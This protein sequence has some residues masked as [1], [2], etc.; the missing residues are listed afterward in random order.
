MKPIGPYHISECEVLV[1]S[2]PFKSPIQIFQK[3]GRAVL[4]ERTGLMVALTVQNKNETLVLQTEYSPLPGIDPRSEDDINKQLPLIKQAI[5]QGVNKLK[6]NGLE[7]YFPRGLEL[8]VP[9]FGMEAREQLKAIFPGHWAN[10]LWEGLFLDLFHPHLP[11]ETEAHGFVS[12]PASFVEQNSPLLTIP[13]IKFKIG[14][15]PITDEINFLNRWHTQATPSQ[16]WRLD[17]NR[18]LNT[19][20]WQQFLDEPFGGRIEFFEEPC[21]DM[22]QM[23]EAEIPSAWAIDE[24]AIPLLAGQKTAP[25]FPP[26]ASHLIL[27]SQDYNGQ[28]ASG[29]YEILK[30]SEWAFQADISVLFSSSYEGP[31]GM[32]KLL[33]MARALT[34]LPSSKGDSFHGLDTLKNLDISA[35]D[36]PFL[37]GRPLPEIKQDFSFFSCS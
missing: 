5:E 19:K 28:G 1:F 26:R 37:A 35:L 17:A 24:S 11:L 7:I 14:R 6:T 18:R 21:M 36:Y 9:F 16:R 4:S 2:L 12:N 8:Q 20:S 29:I 23:V 32:R 33:Q 13:R 31:V 30:W 10:W 3:S 34:Y 27:R 15:L 22:L 25:K